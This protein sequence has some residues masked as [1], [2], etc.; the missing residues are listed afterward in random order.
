LLSKNLKIKKYRTI[1]LSVVYGCETWSL[2]LR[3]VHRLKVFENRVLRGILGPK[4][5]EASGEWRNYIMRNLMICAPHP[6][7]FG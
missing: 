4:R 5:D 2:T 3:E 1:I 7:L 6:I